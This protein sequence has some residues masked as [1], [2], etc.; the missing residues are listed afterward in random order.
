MTKAPVAA[1]AHAAPVAPVDVDRADAAELET[2]PGIG[3]ALARRI[4]EDRAE[5]GSFGGLSGLQQVRG[6][7]PA[8]AAKLAPRVTFSGPPR[9]PRA[10]AS[11]PRSL[12][13]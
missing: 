9:P 7:G 6:I 12:H 5:H 10:A 1:S 4:V 13:P 11:G 3:P 2:L 8:L